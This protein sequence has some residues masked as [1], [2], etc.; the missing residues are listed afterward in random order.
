MGYNFIEKAI[1]IHGNI[2]NYSK[3]I[4][5]NKRTKVIITC[6]THGDFLQSPPLHLKGSGCKK[7]YIEKITFN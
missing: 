1:S 4:Y 3:T 6:Q 2:Y 7:C 5:V